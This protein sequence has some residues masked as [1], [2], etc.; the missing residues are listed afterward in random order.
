MHIN[1]KKDHQEKLVIAAIFF[2]FVFLRIIN[3]NQPLARDE[4]LFKAD[5]IHNPFPGNFIGSQGHP[6]LFQLPNS[7]LASVFGPWNWVFRFT[8]FFSACLTAIVLFY[9]L[10]KKSGIT[11]AA[12][13]LL[14]LA[15]LPWHINA[16]TNAL[17]MSLLALFSLLGLVFAEM[18]VESKKIS[19]LLLC[20]V[21]SYAAA[22]TVLISVVV[23]LTIILYF[24][25]SGRGI[26][27]QAE[28]IASFAMPYLILFGLTFLVVYAIYPPN[29]TSMLFHTQQLGTSSLVPV[30]ELTPVLILFLWAGPLLLL[31]LYFLISR[32][33]S[34]KKNI[35]IIFIA[36]T[37]LVFFI[38]NSDHQRPFDRYF[39]ILIPSLVIIAAQSTSLFISKARRAFVI[40]FAVFFV[41]FLLVALSSPPIIPLE[42]KGAFISHA[43]A[44]MGNIAV[45]YSSNAGPLGFYFPGIAIAACWVACIALL[46]LYL[47]SK[48]RRFLVLAVSCVLA[49]NMVLCLAQT[50]LVGTANADRAADDIVARLNGISLEKNVYVY[51][52]SGLFVYLDGKNVSAFDTY[53]FDKVL[54]GQNYSVIIVN[55]PLIPDDSP[56]WSRLRACSTQFNSSKYGVE[57]AVY[58]C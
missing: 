31:G 53:D 41:L 33:R 50:G 25:F 11:T 55:F 5:Y 2:L 54:V 44:S 27:K 49:F 8:A 3:I 4:A 18:Y 45:P 51:I 17:A 13:G 24:F 32:I 40:S 58:S 21:F 37:I 7:L 36:V 1:L 9:Y 12:L 14:I 56:V 22:I 28:S 19:H 29:I 15:I 20:I 30:I 57:E 35:H 10:R 52:N 48:K 46:A 47:A 38:F 16:S 43:I 6:I 34:I 39:M 42:P 26:K 23:P